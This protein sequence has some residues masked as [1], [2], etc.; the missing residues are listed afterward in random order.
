LRC[1]DDRVSA[2]VPAKRPLPIESLLDVEAL[3]SVEVDREW[4]CLKLDML[5]LMDEWAKISL[6]DGE[7]ILE[8]ARQPSVSC[9]VRLPHETS[10]VSNMA[11]W[12]VQAELLQDAAGVLGKCSG[13]RA[14]LEL[15]EDGSVALAAPPDDPTARYVLFPV[16]GGV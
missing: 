5:T 10:E 9:R 3:A 2:S 14:R 13:S 1:L 4:L 11:G 7:V 16:G 8:A 12:S 15:R 6:I